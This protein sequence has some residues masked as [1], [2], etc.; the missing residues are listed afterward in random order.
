MFK[1]DKSDFGIDLK[2]SKFKV[3]SNK[4]GESFLNVE[5]YGSKAQ[6]ET[7]AADED[8]PWSWVLY[9]PHFYARSI[10]LTP[11]KLPGTFR[12]KITIDDIEEDEL[13]AAVYLV[14]H[15]D[16]DETVITADKSSLQVKGKMFLSGKPRK[17]EIR[18]S[19][20]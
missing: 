6:T 17:F 13:E 19:K 8:G 18:L 4:K 5:I 9:P 7:L 10:P 11:G 15:N 16:L 20:D 1:I 12:A 14:E 2:K 3:S